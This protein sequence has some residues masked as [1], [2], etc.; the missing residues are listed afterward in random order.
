M[1]TLDYNEHDLNI[2]S[3]MYVLQLIK[4]LNQAKCFKQ[5]N[6]CFHLLPFKTN[7]YLRDPKRL[8]GRPLFLKYRNQVK[9]PAGI[10]K[11]ATTRM[12]PSAWFPGK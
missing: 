4:K 2:Q 10:L 9:A 7:N 12:R 11:R 3:I 6:T 8:P 1:L 5:S